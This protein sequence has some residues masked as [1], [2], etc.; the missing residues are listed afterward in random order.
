MKTIYLYQ[1]SA[2]TFG[3]MKTFISGENQSY[4]IS[5]DMLF[6]IKQQHKKLC[7]RVS[8]VASFLCVVIF[9]LLLHICGVNRLELD[10]VY[11]KVETLLESD[12]T[13][14]LG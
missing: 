1:V 3:C 12:G 4:Q 2:R 13:Q 8:S 5:L 14:Y 10:Y 6:Q 9:A 11:L 7:I